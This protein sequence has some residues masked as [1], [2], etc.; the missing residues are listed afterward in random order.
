MMSHSS[1]ILSYRWCL[2][3]Y[4]A[5]NKSPSG[6]RYALA[7]RRNL[8]STLEI[9]H[10]HLHLFRS[11]VFIFCQLTPLN[12]RST[13]MCSIDSPL[14]RSAPFDL[15]FS[16]HSFKQLSLCSAYIVLPH[17][18]LVPITSDRVAIGRFFPLYVLVNHLLSML[19]LR[20]RL[21]NSCIT[22]QWYSYR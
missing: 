22:K 20:L 1:L 2:F 12:A 14:T 19:V 11:R 4:Q 10:N 6:E 15:R 8:E 7:S 5:K 9:L 16:K 21:T 13:S 18:L 17:H 3:I